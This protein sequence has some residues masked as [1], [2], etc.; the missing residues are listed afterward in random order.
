MLDKVKRQLDT[1]PDSVAATEDEN[2]V[3]L[4][5]G[6]GGEDQPTKLLASSFDFLER[7]GGVN[8]M[9]LIRTDHRS[10]IEKGLIGDAPDGLDRFPGVRDSDRV[11]YAKMVSLQLRSGRWSCHAP[12]PVGDA[13]SP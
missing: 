5:L 13:F 6:R 3:C 7:S 12:C 4:L 11:E 9:P 2:A 8:L 10:T 1:I